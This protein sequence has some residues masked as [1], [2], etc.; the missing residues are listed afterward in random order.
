MLWE[1]S[2]FRF[3]VSDF[4]NSISIR[5]SMIFDNRYWYIGKFQFESILKILILMTLLLFTQQ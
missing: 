4:E 5:I 2:Y 3:S 1:F